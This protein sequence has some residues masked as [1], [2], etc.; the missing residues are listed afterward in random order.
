MDKITLKIIGFFAFRVGRNLDDIFC[1]DEKSIKKTMTR[2]IR[3]KFRYSGDE[4]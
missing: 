3:G 4:I 1:H 2:R